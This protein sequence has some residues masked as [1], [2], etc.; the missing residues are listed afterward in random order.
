MPGDGEGKLDDRVEGAD[1]DAGLGGVGGDR[2]GGSS[3][4]KYDSLSRHLN[5]FSTKAVVSAR[6]L[7]SDPHQSIRLLGKSLPFAKKT[8]SWSMHSPLKAA[9]GFSFLKR[10]TTYLA[11]AAGSASQLHQQTSE[12][13]DKDVVYSGYVHGPR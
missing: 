13:Y 2:G 10:A 6:N 4:F 12:R 3:P 11:K 7:K 8:S 5:S 1:D 9:L